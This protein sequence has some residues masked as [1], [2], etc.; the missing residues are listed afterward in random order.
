MRA[1][2]GLNQISV[3]NDRKNNFGTENNFDL[4][5]IFVKKKLVHNTCWDSK[6]CKYNF[7]P[8]MALDQNNEVNVAERILIQKNLI[9]NILEVLRLVQ[10]QFDRK[11]I[12]ASKNTFVPK[13]MLFQSCCSNHVVPITLFQLSC[14]NHVGPCWSMMVHDGP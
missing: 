1:R 2:K 11:I 6:T 5:M 9:T 7:V 8:K 14:S 12:L 3:Q 13:N 4:K 10:K